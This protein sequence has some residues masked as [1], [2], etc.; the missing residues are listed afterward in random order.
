MNCARPFDGW[1]SNRVP[2]KESFK[3][4]C[5]SHSMPFNK[6][7]SSFR[8]S[9]GYSSVDTRQQNDGPQWEVE[10]VFKTVCPRAKKSMEK[11]KIA[12]WSLISLMLSQLIFLIRF[13]LISVLFQDDQRNEIKI[14]EKGCSD[15]GHFISLLV[16]FL[17][18]EK[19][20][21]QKTWLLL[22]YLDRPIK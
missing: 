12:F 21:S 5:G 22:S 2:S 18:R 4:V 9:L 14:N 10:T 6:F 8:R 19:K 3:F 7:L 13:S 20:E 16:S 17:F 15:V 1:R 11:C